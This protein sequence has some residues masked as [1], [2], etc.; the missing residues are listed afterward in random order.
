M[1]PSPEERD[2][3]TII[4][5]AV[6]SYWLTGTEDEDMREWWQTDDAAD[7]A[8][9]LAAHLLDEIQGRLGYTL[10]DPGQG[11]TV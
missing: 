9:E 7:C 6:M 11:R 1:S 3:V 8:R 5:D 2:W 10:N 4:A